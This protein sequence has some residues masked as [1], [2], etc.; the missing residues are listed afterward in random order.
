MGRG[1]FKPLSTRLSAAIT[2]FLLLT[3]AEPAT[4]QETGYPASGAAGQED[5]TLGVVGK[6]TRVQLRF[7]PVTTD[8]RVGD[9]VTE[10][11]VA[12]P[13]LGEKGQV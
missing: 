9:E 8:P 13:G 1:V 12:L 5:E 4:G 11:C 6:E 2:V 7:Q 10:V 3:A